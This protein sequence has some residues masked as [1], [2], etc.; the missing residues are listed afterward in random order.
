MRIPIHVIGEH[1]QKEQARF[2]SSHGKV[3]YPLS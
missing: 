3:T 1:D 2:S